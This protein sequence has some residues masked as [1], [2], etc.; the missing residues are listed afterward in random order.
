MKFTNSEVRGMISTNKAEQAGINRRSFLGAAAAT[1]SGGALFAPMMLAQTREEVRQGTGNHSADNPGPVNKLLQS[2][3]GSSNTPP[4][5]D[6]GDVMPLWYSFELAHRRIQ[7]GGWTRQVTQNDLPDSKDLAGVNMRLTAGSYRELHWHVANE[8]AY[9]LYGSARITVLNPDGTI[10]IDDVQ[11]GD[12]W[13]FPAGFPHSIQGLGPDGCEF[14]LVF[15]QGTFSE[16]QTFLISDW[17]AHT[18]P[19]VLKQNLNLP[20]SAVQK[21]PTDEE[22]I[23]P[24]TIP[25]SLEEDKR[26]VGGIAVESKVSYSFHMRAMKP[27]FED[28]GGSVRIVDS[29][30]FAAS[31]TIAAALVILK[32][33][34]MREMHWHPNASEWQY[35]LQGSG[36]MTVFASSGKA[37]TMSFH[38]NDVGYVPA[39]AGH[40]IENTGT[41]D[42]I[43][44]EM[45]KSAEFCDVSLNQWIRR[46][47]EQIVEQHLHLD[48]GEIQ[49]IP[50]AKDPVLSQ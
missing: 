31:K 17:I 29:S 35:W 5:T 3:N 39:V 34:A 24:G 15:D 50:D 9:M 6:H 32:P 36:R 7:D 4:D 33:G 8:W 40:Y 10:F 48:A 1:L 14:L 49:Q 28:A 43:F 16:Y 13:F 46:L 11:A 21:L 19:A 45:F 41:E 30:V 38:A 25:G 47:P 2:E 20:A 27:T 22:Y 42:V 23:F 44:L 18:P 12:L 37:R 26:A